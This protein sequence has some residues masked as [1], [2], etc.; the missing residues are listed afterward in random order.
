M[1]TSWSMSSLGNIFGPPV[2]KDDGQKEFADFLEANNL[3]TYLSKFEQIG[4][5]TGESNI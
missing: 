3:S 2:A 1:A 4:A 5:R